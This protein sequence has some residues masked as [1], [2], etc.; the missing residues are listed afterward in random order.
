MG[1]TL[2]ELL[3]LCGGVTDGKDLKAIAPSGPSGGFLPARLP[4]R[5]GDANWPGLAARRGFD[6]AAAEL[7]V[8]DLELELD[9]FRALSP[10]EA[11]GAGL[12][13]YAQGRDMADQAVNALQFFRHESCGKCVP[14]RIGSRKLAALGTNLLGGAVD[15]ARWE[16]TLRPL[17]EDLDAVMVRTSICALGRSAPVPLRTVIEFFRGDLDRWLR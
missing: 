17:V 13:V 16:A 3:G 6:P 1:F 4:A 12:V 8:L 10:T 11:L 14:C 7:D 15:A 9:L 5:Q 2:R